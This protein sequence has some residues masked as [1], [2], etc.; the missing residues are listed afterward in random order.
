MEELN[1]PPGI[2]KQIRLRLESF[3]ASNVGPEAEVGVTEEEAAQLNAAIFSLE[4]AEAD[5]PP[6]FAT[7]AAVVAGLGLVSVLV[8]G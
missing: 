2:V 8:L 7:A 3:A 1:I 5:Q 4:E 6:S